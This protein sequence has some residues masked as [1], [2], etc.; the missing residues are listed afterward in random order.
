M[1]MRKLKRI[2]QHCMAKTVQINLSIPPGAAEWVYRNKYQLENVL[3]A[4]LKHLAKVKPCK[5]ASC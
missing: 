2:K 1:N 3:R 4:Y 5:P